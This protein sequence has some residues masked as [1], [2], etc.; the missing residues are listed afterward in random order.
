[1]L[2]VPI[3]VL[4]MMMIVKTAASPLYNNSFSRATV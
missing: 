3:T 2:Q 1:M 4:M